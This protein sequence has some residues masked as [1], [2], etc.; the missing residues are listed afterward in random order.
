MVLEPVHCSNCDGIDVIKHGTT[1]VGKQRYRC[2][3]PVCERGT[4]I[5]EYSYAAYL[6]Q[7]KQQRARYGA[8]R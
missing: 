3:N 1:T 8:Q 2:Q 6:P 4:F 7:V 5:R